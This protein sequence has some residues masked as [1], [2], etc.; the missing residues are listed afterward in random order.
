MLVSWGQNHL[1]SQEWAIDYGRENNGRR[2]NGNI[3]KSMR[4]EDVLLEF[5]SKGNVM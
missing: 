1:L 2:E 3:E 5:L 4:T